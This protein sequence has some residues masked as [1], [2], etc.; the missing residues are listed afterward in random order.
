MVYLGSICEK[1]QWT[2][3]IHRR[4]RCDLSL[5]QWGLRLL[6]YFL[7]EEFTTGHFFQSLN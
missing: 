4:K 2:P 3:I 1:E 6:E 7:N 5:F